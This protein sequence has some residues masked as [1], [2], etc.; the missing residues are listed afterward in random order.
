MSIVKYRRQNR[1]ECGL[2]LLLHYSSFCGNPIVLSVL[3][4]VKCPVCSVKYIVCSVKCP[5]FSVKYIVCTVKYSVCSGKY[6]VF[7]GKCVQCEV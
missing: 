6:I 7:S 5:V 2:T 3:C 4:S 1:G